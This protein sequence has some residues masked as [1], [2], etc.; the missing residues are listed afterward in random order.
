MRSASSLKRSSGSPTLRISLA[1]KSET[2]P[3]SSTSSPFPLSAKALIVK[4]RRARS[5][6]K[7]LVK[8]TS[9]GCLLSSYSPSTLY[10][11]ISSK[12]SSINTATVPCLMPVSITLYPAKTFSVSSGRAFVVMSQ[13]FGTVPRSESRTHP[14][15]T[16]ASKPA[17]FSR[18]R[19]SFA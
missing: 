7:F 2:P 11:V 5:S 15:T 3:N 17:D 9:F 1:F 8:V 13:S 12:L 16:Y 6:F 14:P 4:S 18:S 19:A 10:V